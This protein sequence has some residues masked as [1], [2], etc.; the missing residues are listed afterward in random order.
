M[1]NQGGEPLPDHHRPVQHIIGHAEDPGHHWHHLL[2]AARALML[3]GAAAAVSTLGSPRGADAGKVFLALVTW[4][5]GVCL[6]SF[7]PLAGRFPRA[8]RLAG[9]AMASAGAVLRHLFTPWN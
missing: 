6:L 8:G 9:A 5:L 1:A 3:L 4:L 7:V 2:D